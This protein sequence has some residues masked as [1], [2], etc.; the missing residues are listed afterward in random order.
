MDQS[1]SPPL[2]EQTQH[3]GAGTPGAGSKENTDLIT[4]SSSSLSLKCSSVQQHLLMYPKLHVAS[5]SCINNSY[6]TGG[7]GFMAVSKQPRPR[8]MSSDMV[9][10]L[11]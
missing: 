8:A 4:D 1:D 10:L 2:S 5:H 11:S 3:H 7:Q 9:C 6:S